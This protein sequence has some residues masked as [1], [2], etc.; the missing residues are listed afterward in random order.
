VVLAVQPQKFTFAPMS[1]NTVTGLTAFGESLGKLVVPGNVTALGE[2]A[3]HSQNLRMFVMSEGMLRIETNAFCVPE[4]GFINL[5]DT[6]TH[7]AFH[8][9]SDS[10]IKYEKTTIRISDQLL[11]FLTESYVDYFAMK[12][13]GANDLTVTWFDKQHTLERWLQGGVGVTLGQ[14]TWNTT[15]LQIGRWVEHKNG[16]ICHY[17]LFRLW[18]TVAHEFRHYYQFVASYG[19]GGRNFDNMAMR[20]SVEERDAWHHNIVNYLFPA[21]NFQA[22]L[23]QPVEADARAFAVFY[24]RWQIEG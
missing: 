23:D 1:P 4:L 18:D 21:N 16:E 11:F 5:P 6:L 20:P 22:Y 9:F 13:V 7:L 19:V 3:V 14:Y 12:Y 8:A 10:I 15:V 2:G 24:F 17:W